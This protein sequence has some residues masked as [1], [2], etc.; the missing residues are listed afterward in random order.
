MED[1]QS[2]GNTASLG[3]ATDSAA[4][5]DGADSAS[6]HPG[7]GYNRLVGR[8]EYQYWWYSSASQSPVND[9]ATAA[10]TCIAVAAG[11]SI[12]AAF[13]GI[14]GA[15]AGEPTLLSPSN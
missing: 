8:Y 10:A 7:Y 13:T 11:S 3:E 4:S 2:V 12:P 15:G 5:G 9:V 6:N 14:G 1:I